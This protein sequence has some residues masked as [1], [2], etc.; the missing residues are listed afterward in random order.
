MLANS[1]LRFLPKLLRLF[2]CDICKDE[3]FKK[4]LVCGQ[5]GKVVPEDILA[6]KTPFEVFGMYAKAD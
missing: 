4:D 6:K 1:R 3:N 5:C 2:H